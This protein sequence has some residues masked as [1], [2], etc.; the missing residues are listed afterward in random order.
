MATFAEI[1]EELRRLRQGLW[2]VEEAMEI[3]ESEA[4]A[5]NVASSRHITAPD[6]KGSEWPVAAPTTPETPASSL[7][8]P[9]TIESGAVE[10]GSGCAHQWGVLVW[11]N[12]LYKLERCTAGWP[13][14]GC[15]AWRFGGVIVVPAAATS[16]SISQK[17]A[18]DSYAA[19]SARTAP[20][21]SN[22]SGE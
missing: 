14:E 15:G 20:L 16:P 21:A 1:R 5:Q 4:L 12:L 9:T 8:A 18:S 7:S 13:Q 2:W 17:P 22:E 3:I 11:S 19:P 6:T 10:P